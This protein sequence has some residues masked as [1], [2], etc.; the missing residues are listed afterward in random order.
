MTTYAFFFAADGKDF[1]MTGTGLTW[2]DV[3]RQALAVLTKNRNTRSLRAT[4][5]G[6]ELIDTKGGATWR[7]VLDSEVK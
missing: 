7:W 6:Y 4:E 3:A 1:S 5:N 2:T